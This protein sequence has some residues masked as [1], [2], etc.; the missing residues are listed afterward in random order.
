MGKKKGQ[1][2]PLIHLEGG[3]VQDVEGLPPR[4]DYQVF[5]WDDD[6]GIW[7]EVLPQDVNYILRDGRKN[8]TTDTAAR[9]SAILDRLDMGPPADLKG[10][11]KELMQRI[12]NAR[13]L[14]PTDPEAFL[15]LV[16]ALLPLLRH[17]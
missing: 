9:V 14:A 3:N 1:K 10:A 5:Y 17:A 6:D 4:F 8:S 16:K 11:G 7:P 13:R 15:V 2:T 12:Q